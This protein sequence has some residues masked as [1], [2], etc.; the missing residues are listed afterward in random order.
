VSTLHHRLSTFSLLVILVPGASAAALV[1]GASAAAL[2]PGAS[3]AALPQPSPS[4]TRER[5]R[6]PYSAGLEQMRNEDFA[7]AR[8]SFEAAISIEPT[9][10]L[11]HYMLGRVHLAQKEYAPAAAALTRARDLYVSQAGRKFVDKQEAQR[12]RR[13]RLAEIE[14]L[15]SNLQGVTPMTFQVREQIRQLEERKR[16]VEDLDR[17]R[18][19]TPE[20]QVPAFVSLSLGS[21]YFRLGKKAEAEQAYVAAVAAD[22][23]TG[24]AHNNLAVLYLETG[25]YAQAKTAL[26]AAEKAGVRVHPELKAQIEGKGGSR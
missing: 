1:P 9:F 14:G 19:L 21:A 3:A 15:I 16:Q 17:A 25:R 7:G 18:D 10:E 12:H 24:E 6:E 5:A 23:K 13:E 26:K 4:S 20:Q 11:A 22:P 8:K 2:V